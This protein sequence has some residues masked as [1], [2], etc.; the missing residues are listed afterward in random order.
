MS[1]IVASLGILVDIKVLLG[2]AFGTFLG[3]VMGALPGLTAT[4]AIALLIPLT[5]G[6]PPELGIGMLLG[7]FCGA[8]AGGAVPAILLNVPGT[9]SSVASTLD[10]F[11]MTRR[12][13][14]GRALGL[15]IASSFVGG[16]LGAL[17]LILFAPPIATFALRFG[18]AEFFSLA[19]LGLV[20]IAAVSTK[21]IL[22]GL[23]A[24]CLGIFLSTVGSDPIT[25][26]LRFTMGEP[27]LITGV[28]LLPA[29]IGLFAISQVF[30]D[31][32]ERI[33]QKKEPLKKQALTSARPPWGTLRRAWKVVASSTL[34]GTLV[35]AIPGAGGSVASFLSYDQA[36]RMSKTPEK[37]G[38]GH[39]EGLIATES[40]NN[41]MA[42][43][44]LIPMLTL[45]VPGEVATAVLMGGL[46]I[47]GIR[48]GP[49]LFEQSGAL[50]YSIF[51]A[52]L[53]ANIFMFLIQLFGIKLFVQ[54]L[55]VK[56]AYL[57]PSILVLSLLGVYAATGN[58]FD[59]YLALAF[60]A[61]G[62]LLNVFGFGTAPVI[63]GLILG[64]IAESNLRRGMTV[65][66][67]DWTRFFTQPI[68]LALLAATVLL[69][70]FLFRKKSPQPLGS[71][72]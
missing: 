18:P 49:M 28:N 61:L 32:F 23:V 48:P 57:M 6:F 53:L 66:N 24:G 26:V 20:V 12:G 41:A 30:H 58:T 21:S 55:R 2:I 72:E 3:L 56:E 54:I 43:G 47:Q 46:T 27:S 31:V 33:Y 40:S 13:E 38:T 35:G 11:P 69:L 19:I 62:F 59:M 22:K 1:D 36:R 68:S 60:G 16:M 10:G 34:I 64:G 7:A 8:V 52:F 45:G 17:L 9:P 15:A 5:F 25:G 42:S 37:F 67:D 4:M 44:A 14:A 63:L 71:G 29:L 39:D 70:F 65:F 51:V 50:I